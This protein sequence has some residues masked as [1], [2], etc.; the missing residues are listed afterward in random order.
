MGYAKAGSR[1]SLIAGGVSGLVL[2]GS[3][4]LARSQPILGLVIACVVSVALVA[5]FGKAAFR[6]HQASPVAYVMIGGGV[7]VVVTAG[8]AML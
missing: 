1:A 2:V 5:R 6:K 4:L 3:A 7:A 8:L